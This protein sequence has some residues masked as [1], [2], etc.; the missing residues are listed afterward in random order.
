MLW[1]LICLSNIV[2]RHT[3]RLADGRIISHAHPY[4]GFWAKCPFPNHQHTRAELAWLDCIGN[5]PFDTP[6]P[7]VV[8]PLPTVWLAPTLSYSYIETAGGQRF[9]VHFLRGP[10]TGAV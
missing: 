1:G 9:F 8:C 2:F 4:A 5:A 7:E 6:A 10:P 3:H